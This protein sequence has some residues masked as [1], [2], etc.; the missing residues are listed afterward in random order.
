M[1]ALAE[2]KYDKWKVK[3]LSLWKGTTEVHMD[4]MRKFSAAIPGIESF[5]E[6]GNKL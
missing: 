1:W 6:R 4:V 3:D 2:T 5:F